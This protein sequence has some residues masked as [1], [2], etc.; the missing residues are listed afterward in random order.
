MESAVADPEGNLLITARAGNESNW[1]LLTAD[2]VTAALSQ[3]F[4]Q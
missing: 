1:Y 4:Q 3:L 2:Q